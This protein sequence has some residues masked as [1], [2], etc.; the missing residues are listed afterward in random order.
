MSLTHSDYCLAQVPGNRLSFECCSSFIHS[1]I[2]S[3]IR[4]TCHGCQMPSSYRRVIDKAGTSSCGSSQSVGKTGWLTYLRGWAPS[5][6]SRDGSGLYWLIA[7]REFACEP[8]HSF[9]KASWA[10]G[11]GKTQSVGRL[12]DHSPTR[13]VFWS[14]KL[15]R[16]SCDVSRDDGKGCKSTDLQS[17]MPRWTSYP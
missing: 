4:E 16:L 5:F 14:S 17:F 13:T 7:Y 2:H 10:G 11:A 9:P 15:A 6:F 1:F 8:G 12:G 3:F